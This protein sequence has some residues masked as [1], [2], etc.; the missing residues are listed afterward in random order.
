MALHME[1]C[2]FHNSSV[3]T[4]RFIADHEVLSCL[5]HRLIIMDDMMGVRAIV[6]RNFFGAVARL[7]VIISMST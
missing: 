3:A 2:L 5:I 7:S 1:L 6:C 4:H